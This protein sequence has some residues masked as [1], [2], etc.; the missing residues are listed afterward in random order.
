MKLLQHLGRLAIARRVPRRRAVGIAF[1]AALAAVAAA[2]GAAQAQRGPLIGAY[3][4]PGE[5]GVWPGT[6]VSVTFDRPMDAAS[7]QAS[8]SLQPRAD[9]RLRAVDEK[10]QSFTFEP[11]EP[12]APA[13]KHTATLAA[14]V[15][16]ARATSS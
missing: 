8:F 15:R 9:G 14:G 7:V 10:L 16:D 6:T 4:Q 1:G 13:T 12:F 11:A 3:P 5:Q 2:G